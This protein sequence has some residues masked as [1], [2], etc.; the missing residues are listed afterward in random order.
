MTLYCMEHATKISA[1]VETWR[2]VRGYEGMYEVSDLARVR[3]LDKYR[4]VLDVKG[5]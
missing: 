2:P 5:Q 1:A 3:S 4:R